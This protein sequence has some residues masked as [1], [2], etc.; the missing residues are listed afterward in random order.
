VECSDGYRLVGDYLKR[1]KPRGQM[2]GVIFLHEDGRD[3]H[4]WHSQSIFTAARQ[5]ACLALDLR[6]YGENP[7][8]VGNPA[9]TASAYTDADYRL[10]LDDV[11]D[12]VAYLA[13]KSEI[14]GGR[15]ALVGSGMGANVALLA[16]GQPWAEAVQVVIA[17]SPE[18][19]WKGLS[20]RDA[21]AK[22]PSSTRVYLA[23]AKDD[24]ASWSACETLMG[25]L[26]GPKE[27]W[28]TD[29][30]GRG[31]QIFQG[32]GF[33]QIPV[34]LASNLVQ[35]DATPARARPAPRPAR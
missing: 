29:T 11:R 16:A 17:V 26:R 27:F 18:I 25:V 20:V 13:V 23:A 24:P 8:T 7:G 19:E 14:A 28:K 15:L 10:M 32:H 22:I 6:G 3:R 33:H 31:L 1:S 21:A 4:E 30:G 5:C 2:P 34:W 35:A 12:A 9:K